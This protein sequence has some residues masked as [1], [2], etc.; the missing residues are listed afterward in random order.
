MTEII[1]PAGERPPIRVQGFEQIPCYLT[2]INSKTA[3]FRANNISGEMAT[4]ADKITMLAD[5]PIV[6]KVERTVTPREIFDLVWGTGALDW[7]WWRK[8]TPLRFG[9]P[10]EGWQHAEDGLLQP[11]DEIEFVIDDP[12]AGEGDD[13][14]PRRFVRSLADIAEAA[15]KAQQYISAESWRDM[16]GDSIGYADAIEADVILQIAVFGKII[17]G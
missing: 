13:A 2:K 14:R 5:Q 7:D 6:M 3:Y 10:I 11:G 17:Y 16:A 9:S 15:G 8:A 4:D 12:D 1:Y